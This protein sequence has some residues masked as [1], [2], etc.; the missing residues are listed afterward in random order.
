MFISCVVCWRGKTFLIVLSVVLFPP[1]IYLF[2]KMC[3]S[4]C[5]GSW[6]AEGGEEMEGGRK[7]AE[8]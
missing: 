4:E 1:F 6:S 2:F 5:D 7:R 3:S 8:C